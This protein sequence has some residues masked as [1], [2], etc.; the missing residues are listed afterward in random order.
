MNNS[1]TISGNVVRDPELRHTGSGAATTSFGVAV[2]RRVFTKNDTPT[3]VVSYFNVIAWNALAEHVCESLRKGARVVVTGRF[4]QRSWEVIDE[5][6]K[7]VRKVSFELVAEDI[8]ASLRFAT[9]T[10]HRAQ[11]IAAQITGEEEFSVSGQGARDLV[12]AGVSSGTEF[13]SD[14]APF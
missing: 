14:D 11:R 5:N 13:A 7:T 2:N 4:D 9:A 3:E 10:L 8:G 6:G 12:G 1:I